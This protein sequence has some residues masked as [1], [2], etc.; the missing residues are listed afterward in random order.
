M[1]S[2]N[3]RAEEQNGQTAQPQ[4]P[5]SIHCALVLEPAAMD[6]LEDELDLRYHKGFDP[7]VYYRCPTLEV[8]D[9]P[10]PSLDSAKVFS[11]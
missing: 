8:T 7:D 2:V 5:P 11:V 1:C 9:S 4:H 6:Q 10:S 3:R